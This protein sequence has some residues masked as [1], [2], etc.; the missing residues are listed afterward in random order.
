MR[1]IALPALLVVAACSTSTESFTVNGEEVT[2]AEFEELVGSPSIGPRSS[3]PE[4]AALDDLSESLRQSLTGRSNSTFEAVSSRS[5][6]ATFTGLFEINTTGAPGLAFQ[7]LSE[8]T[9]VADFRAEEIDTQ[10]GAFTLI[11]ENG[12][13]IET[14]SSTIS[15]ENGR[16]GLGLPNA[17]DFRVTGTVEGDGISLTANG[18]IDGQ[19]RG[20]PIL[21]LIAAG[22]GTVIINGVAPPDHSFR[23]RAVAD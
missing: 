23:L 14:T 22:G 7:A 20:T 21:G 2:R 6:E 19:F 3:N 18:F 8:A 5:D 12:D 9:L 16:I 4:A 17:V 11:D 15:L 1:L 13:V 10:L